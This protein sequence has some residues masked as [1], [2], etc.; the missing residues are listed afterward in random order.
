MNL[1]PNTLRLDFRA[2]TSGRKQCGPTS[3]QCGNSCIPRNLNCRI[4]GKG[5]S[6]SKAKSSPLAKVGRA[7]GTVANYA[8]PDIA[9]ALIVSGGSVLLRQGLKN[10]RKS[11]QYRQLSKG[12]SRLVSRARYGRPRG[13]KT[14]FRRSIRDSTYA[15][16]FNVDVAQLAL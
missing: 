4:E 11:Y 1:S 8:G 14:D 9:A 3:K 12:T 10:R 5:K 2:S 6:A 7:L 16:G 15:N 13:S